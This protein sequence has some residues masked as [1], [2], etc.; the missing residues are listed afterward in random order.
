MDFGDL[1]RLSSAQSPDD[2]P[3]TCSPL[4][5]DWSVALVNDT[6]PPVG[7]GGMGARS[8]TP[9]S[10]GPAFVCGVVSLL[11]LYCCLFCVL[12]TLYQRASY[13]TGFM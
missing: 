2:P 8:V 1:T 9:P 13:A 3:A 12:L 5:L 11:F 10:I 6:P 4:G 7:R